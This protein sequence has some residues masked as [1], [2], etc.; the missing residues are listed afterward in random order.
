VKNK[1]LDNADPQTSTA[2]DMAV[3]HM[4]G[5]GSHISHAKLLQTEV[6][7]KKMLKLEIVQTHAVLNVKPKEENSVDSE[8]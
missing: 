6:L 4:D 1:D 8:F 3:N 2:V 7:T 5:D